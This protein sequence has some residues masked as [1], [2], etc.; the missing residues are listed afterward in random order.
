LELLC[1][2]FK[3]SD[4]IVKRDITPHEIQKKKE[5]R[6]KVRKTLNKQISPNKKENIIKQKDTKGKE[7]QAKMKQGL[8]KHT[9][10]QW[11]MILP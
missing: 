8:N 9:S 4:S 5:K 2:A 3:A 10:S 6:K 7:K 1:V 11:Y